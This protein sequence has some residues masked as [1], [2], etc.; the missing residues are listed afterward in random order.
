MCIFGFSTTACAKGTKF[1]VAY[2]RCSP[3]HFISQF[4]CKTMYSISQEDGV[5]VTVLRLISVKSYIRSYI[6]Y[7]VKYWRVK[8]LSNGLILRLI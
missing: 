6:P 5:S 8:T 3:K 7:V 2:P 1:R 4:H